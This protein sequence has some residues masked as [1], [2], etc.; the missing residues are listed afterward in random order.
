MTFSG[1]KILNEILNSVK[2]YDFVLSQIA[3]TSKLE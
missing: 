3:E 1:G 2:F